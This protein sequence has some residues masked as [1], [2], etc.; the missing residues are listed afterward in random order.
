MYLTCLIGYDYQIQY[1]ADNH[2]QAADALSRLPA[3]ESSMSMILSVPSLTF[4]EELRRQ[5]NTYP[6]YT[7][8]RQQILEDPT[9]QP[10]EELK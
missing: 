3:Q 7:Q 8:Q 2:N 5:L 1:R 6:E 10:F 9:N 4:L